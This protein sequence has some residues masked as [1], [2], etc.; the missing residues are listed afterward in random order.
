[1]QGPFYQTHHFDRYKEMI[2]QLL[3][4]GDAYYCYCSQEELEHCAPSKWPIR[5]SRAITV[6]AGMHARCRPEGGAGGT[7]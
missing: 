3:D 2:Q 5:K 6:N 7:F 4:Q 1:M